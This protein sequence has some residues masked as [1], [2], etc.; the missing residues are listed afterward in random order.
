M[1]TTPVRT[2]S[3]DATHLVIAAGVTEGERIV[4]RGAELI[5]QDR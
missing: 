4:I 3:F 2:Q 5:N 1:H